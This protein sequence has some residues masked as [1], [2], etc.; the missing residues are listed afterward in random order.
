VQPL[1]AI[2]SLYRKVEKNTRRCGNI[3]VFTLLRREYK[4]L[5][6]H[7]ESWSLLNFEAIGDRHSTD[8]HACTA[9]FGAIFVVVALF[10]YWE[11]YAE[12]GQVPGIE[13]GSKGA[14]EDAHQAAERAVFHYGDNGWYCCWYG[15]GGCIYKQTYCNRR[16]LFRCAV[17]D[18]S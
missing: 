10:T 18:S 12:R 15:S 7:V 8:L 3:R 5:P 14:A 4:A 11:C 1:R 9:L 6:A 13:V 17:L 2:L 16:L